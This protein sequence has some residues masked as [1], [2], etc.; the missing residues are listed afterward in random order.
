MEFSNWA[1]PTPTSLRL[2]SYMVDG[3]E[4]GRE[5]VKPVY[6]EPLRNWEVRPPG[7]ELEEEPE[8]VSVVPATDQRLGY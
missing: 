7:T 1:S 4:T 6:E 2:G 3:E 8:G 5:E